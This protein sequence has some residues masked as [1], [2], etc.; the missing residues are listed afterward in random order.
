MKKLILTI[1]SVLCLNCMLCFAQNIYADIHGKKVA[2]LTKNENRLGGKLYHSDRNFISL[3]GTADPIV[4]R[5]PEK[6]G[7]P[8]LLVYYTFNKTDSLMDNIFYE[9]DISN[10]EKGDNNVKSLGFQKLLIQKYNELLKRLT[11]KYGKSISTGELTDLSK[12]DKLHGLQ[13]Q[14]IWNLNDSTQV[15]MYTV[16]TNYYEKE[17]NTIVTTPD[18][19]IRIFIRNI[20]KKV[21]NEQDVKSADL[22][23]QSFVSKLV[24]NDL[25]GSRQYLSDPV[26]E[27]TDLQL[28]GTRNHVK[29]KGNLTILF[30]GFGTFIDEKRY[31]KL[32]YKG[33][34][35]AADQPSELI[36]VMFDRQNKILRVV[37]V[38]R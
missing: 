7:L 10:F 29:D 31:L 6:N 1:L 21:L 20:V 24:S 23:F 36:E 22:N 37:P 3:D 27:I 13:R 28:T 17:G 14:D 33:T 8:D 16:I 4:F 12:I 32:Q 9:W 18:H 2:E 30:K 26:K 35:L 34:N 5:R 25:I 11:A 38:N 15:E 19:K